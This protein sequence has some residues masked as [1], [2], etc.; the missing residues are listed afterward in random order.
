MTTPND[1]PRGPS[2]QRY[3]RFVDDYKRRRLDDAT[4]AARGLRPIDTAGDRS[5]E[6]DTSPRRSRARR[7]YMREYLRWLRPYR[8]AIGF[9]FLLALIR[10]GLEMVEPLFMR[11][12]IDRVLLN[13]GLDTATRLVRLH[14]A[15]LFFLVVVVVSSL[16]SVLK[17]YRQRVLNVRV[18]LSLRRTLFESPVAPAVATAVGHEDGRHPV[19]AHRRHRHDDRPVADGDRVAGDFAHPAARSP[20]ACC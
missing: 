12:I 14:G 17:E 16:V 3:Q 15:G 5:G 20:W 8:Y 9:V 2:R 13:K 18:M 6:S 11:F 4:D 7:Q 19:A 1:A 10:G